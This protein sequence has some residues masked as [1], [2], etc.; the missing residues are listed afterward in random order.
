VSNENEE[1]NATDAHKNVKVIVKFTRG[2]FAAL[3]SGI[4]TLALKETPS[5]KII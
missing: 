4:H 5:G 3:S 1:L 2:R